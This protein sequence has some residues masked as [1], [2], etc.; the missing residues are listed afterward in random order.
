MR[1]WSCLSLAK[2]DRGLVEKGWIPITVQEDTSKKGYQAQ[3]CARR[4]IFSLSPC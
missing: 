3:L 2:E 1:E 4:L